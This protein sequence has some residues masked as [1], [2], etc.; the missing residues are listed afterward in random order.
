MKIEGQRDQ[1][2]IDVQV[3][4]LSRL[5]AAVVADCCDAV[6]YRNQIMRHDMRPI[7]Q[8]MRVVGV[9]STVL[10]VEVYSIPAEPYVH[11]LEAV[12]ALQPHDIFVATTNGATSFALWG[13]L[14]S[15]RARMRGATGAV[16]DGFSRD[17][18]RIGDMG[19]PTFCTGLHLGDSQGRGDV[20]ASGVPI[21]CGDVIVHPGDYLIADIDGVCVVPQHAI[22]EVLQLAEEKIQSEDLVRTDLAAGRS[23]LE[24]YHQYGVM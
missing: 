13:E 10:C 20:I 15:T 9:A 8:E 23:V 3:E 11:E 5:Y 6:G 4:R 14:L 21:R 22:I 19:F 18:R 1:N 16:I 2:F 12:D 7:A 24:T 17:A